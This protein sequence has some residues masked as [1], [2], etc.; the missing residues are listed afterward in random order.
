VSRKRKKRAKPRPTAPLISEGTREQWFFLPLTILLCVV[1]YWLT[2]CPTVYVGDSGELTTAAYHL[3]IPHS[4]GYPLYCLTGWVFTHLAIPGDIGFRMNVMSAFFAL[5]TVIVL[6]MIIYHFTRTPYLSFS[7]SL[8]Y[9]FSPIFW[10]QAVVAEV[11]S[12]N[13]F[14]TA[15]ALYFLCRWVEKR[16]DRWLF[17]ASFIMGLAATNHQL[18]LLLVPTGIF[19]LALFKG[20]KGPVVHFTNLWV[21][22]VSLFIFYG[23]GLGGAYLT[24]DAIQPGGFTGLLL[25]TIFAII[26][27]VWSK[28]TKTLKFWLI[29]TGLYILGFMV[30]LYL[31]IRA[32]AD[33]PLN[34]GNM[35]SAGDIL[36]SI[37]KPASA[38]VST[39]NRFSHFLNAL[40]LW[41]FQFSPVVRIGPAGT[42]YPVPII[43]IFGLWGIIKGLSTG[44]RMAKVLLWFMFL[45]IATILTVSRPNE[46]EMLIVG[47]YYLP[48]F[49]VF[50]VFM[51]T[52]LREWLQTFFKA[53]GEKKRPV[54]LF[55]VILILVLIPIMQF[56]DNRA[57]ADR[58]QDF[59]AR[60]YATA[61]LMAVPQDSVL[62]VNWD[63]IFTIWYLQ[64]VEEIRPDVIPVL[65]N[66]PSQEI[67]DY[68][69]RWY[70]EE[71]REDHPELFDGLDFENNIYIYKEDALDAFVRKNLNDG[72]D[73]YFSFYGIGYNFERLNFHIFP[74]GIVYKA[75]FEDYDVPTLVVTQE[76]WARTLNEIRNI[77]SYYMHGTSEDGF[78]IYR[79]SDNL[80]K[81]G[82]L[83]LNLEENEHAEWFL[84]SAVMV[85]TGNS[86]ARLKLAE[87]K[88]EQGLYKEAEDL[89]L[90]GAEEIDPRNPEIW[91]K[92]G[93]LY[94]DR[95][96]PELAFQ[97]FIKTLELDQFHPDA[98]TRLEQVLLM[99]EN[100][101]DTDN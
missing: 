87:L 91:F 26:L 58:S 95:N 89:L 80:L 53:F 92:L 74:R 78:I 38:Q 85:D 63:D 33:P 13:T 47:V 66:F 5:G 49:L 36:E 1:A 14:L 28:Y 34:W 84:E 41:I 62:I 86:H 77:D 45:N 25:P 21:M 60:D 59:Y 12:L 81:C 4:P 100:R 32:A 101:Q 37:I 56:R 8:A 3:G 93:M 88:H 2:I 52:G 40:N 43:W 72:R 51:A 55:L 96:Q 57:E 82:Q 65:P 10:T 50:A 42:P 15:L 46:Q 9:A 30:Y 11:Y 68:W 20:S 90:E 35:S 98:N 22:I 61:L 23:L 29:L 73:V 83:A 54:L 79:M 7:I 19:M 24:N 76:A 48:V 99:M 27:L 44:W 67:I 39:G 18:A 70:F 17:F 97:A 31:P 69:G 6:Y 94:L 75:G 64:K 71:T 16:E